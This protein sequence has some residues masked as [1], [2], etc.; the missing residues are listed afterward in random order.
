MSQTRKVSGVKTSVRVVNGE[1]AVR[2]HSTDVVSFDCKKITLRSG[3]Y[4]TLTTK[5]RMNQ[6]SNQFDLGY[7]VY[8]KDGGWYVFLV[9]IFMTSR[10]G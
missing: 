4:R 5:L 8:Q 7:S 6:A 1:T 3:G 2:Y 10:T 9:V